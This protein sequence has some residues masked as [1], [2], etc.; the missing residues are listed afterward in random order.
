MISVLEMILSCSAPTPDTI[1]YDTPSQ[2]CGLLVKLL[3]APYNALPIGHI[4]VHH[5]IQN[6]VQIQSDTFNVKKII[7][8]K[9]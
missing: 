8:T 3:H 9:N 7:I 4:C 1:N 6:P 2:D 5:H